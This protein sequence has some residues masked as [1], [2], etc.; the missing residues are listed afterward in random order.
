MA[1]FILFAPSFLGILPVD[2]AVFLSFTILGIVVT[3]RIKTNLKVYISKN[4]L[5]YIIL[6]AYAILSL[7]WTSNKEGQLIYVFALGCA[8][9]FSEMSGEYFAENAGDGFR[10]RIMYMLSISGI[11]CATS[12]LFY[13]IFYIVP[14]AGNEPFFLG[15]GSNNFLGIYM[16]LCIIVSICLLKGNSRLR[17]ILILTSVL[18]MTFVFIMT[19]SIIA[20]AMLLMLAIVWLFKKKMKSER[21]FVIISLVCVFLFF[22]IVLFYLKYTIYG[23]AF[24]DAFSY[25]SGNLFGKGG[26]FWNEREIFS[27]IH[28]SEKLG[29][30]LFAYI[31]GASGML[32]ILACVFLTIRNIVAFIRLKS[33]ESLLGIFISVALMLLP[34]GENITLILLWT[35]INAYNEQAAEK[36]F[37]VL[38]KKNNMD[39]T[40]C[41]AIAFLVIASIL[42]ILSFLKMNAASAYKKKDYTTSYE[43]Y[44]VAATVNRTDSESCRMAVSSIRKSGLLPSMRDEAV[45][46]IDTAIKRDLKNLANL[47]EKALVY[48][49]CGEYE[50]SAQLYREAVQKAV[51][52]DDYNLALVKGLYKIVEMNPKGSSETKRAYEE[53][54]SIAQMTDNLNLRKE[55]NDIADKALGYTKGELTNEK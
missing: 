8:M 19:K 20:W 44:K 12:N 46:I 54:V 3:L 16:A 6:A 38:L 39:K 14:V 34:F 51:I 32:G 28:Y 7:L 43:L 17:K 9:I 31:F 42:A 25:A 52:K 24:K 11:I 29:V 2:A 33:Y 1:V 26:G 5:V 55:I 21:N 49:A 47:K 41:A 18:V 4:T 22:L 15:L 40:M 48:E 50:L 30:G 23:Q 53:I 13:W 45:K 37:K 35:A 10:R 36:N 27:S